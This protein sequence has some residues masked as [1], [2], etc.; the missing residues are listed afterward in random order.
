MPYPLRMCFDGACY[1]VTA[2]GNNRE[3]IFH[4]EQDYQ[5][6][7]Q[8]LHR[9]KTRFR[10]I[11]HAYALM[12]N[13][14]HMLLQ[15]GPGATISR[16]M[17]SLTISYTRY[18]NVRYRRVGHVF[19]GRFHS[20]LV[21]ND[22]Y[23]LVASRYIH[24]NPVRAKLVP[25]LEAYPWSSYR[26]YLDPQRNLLGLTDAETVLG[27]G[28][29]EKSRQRAAYRDFVESSSREAI[30]RSEIDLQLLGI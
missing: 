18:F 2:R 7:L 9:Y 28:S 30:Q 12:P 17:Q 8:L 25:Q 21:Q 19:Q 22:T 10:C 14:V 24:L 15:P 26:A 6:Y 5:Q 16:V 29:Q 3:P 23:L 4:D 20:R 11:F 1:H 27:L 13:H